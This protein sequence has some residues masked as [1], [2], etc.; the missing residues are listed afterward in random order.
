MVRKLMLVQF[1]SQGQAYAVEGIASSEVGLSMAVYPCN[2]KGG[3]LSCN[4]AGMSILQN[5]TLGSLFS[6]SYEVWSYGLRRHGE[7]ATLWSVS[8]N[9]I[10]AI[11]LS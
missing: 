1:G 8:E 11:L 5:G 4:G 9:R 2:A 6:S 10:L 3:A 7:N